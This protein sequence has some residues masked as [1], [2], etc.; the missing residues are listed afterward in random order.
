MLNNDEL[1]EDGGFESGTL[2]SYCVCDSSFQPTKP[3]KL[4][5]DGRETNVCKVNAFFSAVQLSQ[6]VN[7]IPGHNYNV[8]FWLTG[9]SSF[10][11]RE[12]TVY[13]S[14]VLSIYQDFSTLLL[15]TIIINFFIIYQ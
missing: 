8:R 12:V 11:D 2:Y 4:N 10:K 14:S 9:Q 3:Q 6:Q 5:I 13:M 1:I 7:T 15:K